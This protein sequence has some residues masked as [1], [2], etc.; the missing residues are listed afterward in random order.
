VTDEEVDVRTSD[1]EGAAP[2]SPI[3]DGP[4]PSEGA[5]VEVRGYRLRLDRAYDPDTHLWALVVAPGRVRIGL[6]P[7][8][9]ETSGTVAQLAPV[10][11]GTAVRRGEPAGSLE[12]EKFVGPL[13]SPV[14]GTVV[15]HN[16]A[17][18][19][20]PGLVHRDPY[21]DGWI[22]ELVVEPSRLDEELPLLVAGADQTVPWFERK[23]A[24]YREQ[25]VLAE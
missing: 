20:D 9:V 3:Q 12:A 7:L 13:P 8:G 15:A 14:S 23:L 1:P 2:A 4:A 19:A 10:P 22:L 16:D 25:G 5:I 21:D 6:D 24:E 11:V 18:V 17:V